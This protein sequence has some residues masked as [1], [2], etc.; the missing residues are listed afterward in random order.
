MARKKKSH[1]QLI[2]DELQ[3][4]GSAVGIQGI[5][6]LVDNRQETPFKVIWFG[7]VVASFVASGIC[8]WNSVEG[9]LEKHSSLTS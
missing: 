8:I 1:R 9:E 6:Y 2:K 3:N 4:F 5:R 7:I